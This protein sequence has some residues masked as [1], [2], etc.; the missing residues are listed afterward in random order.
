MVGICLVA[1]PMISY[2]LGYEPYWQD[3]L[4]SY[5]AA[6]GVLAHGL[7]VL[8]S[9]FLYPKG[10]LYSYLLALSMLIFGDHGA[11]PRVLSVL[12]YLVSLPLFYAIGCY[13]FEKRIALLATGPG[14]VRAQPAGAWPVSAGP[15]QVA[16]AAAPIVRQ[17]P[18]KAEAAPE[19]AQKVASLKDKAEVI[20][21]LQDSFAYCA[22]ALEGIDDQ[23]VLAS[24]QMTYSLLH[25]V[26]RAGNLVRQAHTAQAWRGVPSCPFI[27]KT[28]VTG[29]FDHG[30]CS[31]RPVTGCTFLASI[32]AGYR[33]KPAATHLIDFR[34]H[35]ILHRSDVFSRRAGAQHASLDHAQFSAGGNGMCLGHTQE[36]HASSLLRMV[37]MPVIWNADADVY[38]DF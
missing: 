4:T 27:Q 10:E 22:A 32:A 1:L 2:N 5:F 28:L 12:E 31:Q 9:G 16:Q 30:Q 20:Q 13:F 15:S 17:D 6:K 14:D 18:A 24:P 3:E 34:Q 38:A 19:S 21:A 26:L 35:P 25:V 7:P 8:S 37:F 11:G 23:K 29:H 36:K 33:S